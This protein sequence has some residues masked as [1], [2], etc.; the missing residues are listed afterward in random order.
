[1]FIAFVNVRLCLQQRSA[2]KY[3]Q[4]LRNKNV[5][6]SPSVSMHSQFHGFQLPIQIHENFASLKEIVFGFLVQKM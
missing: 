1:L 5:R 2:V 3:S 4:E 6:I